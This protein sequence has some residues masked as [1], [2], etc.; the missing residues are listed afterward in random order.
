MPSLCH[1]CAIITAS[2]HHRLNEVPS[3]RHDRTIISPSLHAGSTTTY[4]TRC[5]EIICETAL[6][7]MGRCPTCRQFLHLVN[8]TVQVAE[9]FEQC[10]CCNQSRPVSE[11]LPSGQV[12]CAACAVGVRSPLRYECERCHGLSRIPHPM[13]RYQASPEEVAAHRSD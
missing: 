11:R 2:L 6:G 5:I 12:L 8:G 3:L 4:C 9:G 10:N 13:Y 1:H 7:G